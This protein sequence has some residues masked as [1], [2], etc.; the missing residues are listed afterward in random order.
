MIINHI[1]RIEFI[2]PKPKSISS[3][4][5]YSTNLFAISIILCTQK[6]SQNLCEGS[7]IAFVGSLFIQFPIFIW[8]FVFSI[9]IATNYGKGQLND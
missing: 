6:Q 5:Y 2:E 9:I 8:T 4:H 3:K 1:I 7:I